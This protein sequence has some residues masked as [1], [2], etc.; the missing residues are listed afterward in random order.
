[1][2]S[3]DCYIG[4]GISVVLF[5]FIIG[6]SIAECINGHISSKCYKNIYTSVND[7]VME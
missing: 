1:M 3:L 6:M 2:D 4:L 7:N 5:V